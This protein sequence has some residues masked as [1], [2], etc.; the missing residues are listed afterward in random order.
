[1]NNV[2]NLLTGSLVYIACI[3]LLSLACN[4]S[5]GLPVADVIGQWLYF[6]KSALVVA[7]CLLMAGLMMEKGIF[8]YTGFVGI[9]NAGGIEAVWG[10]SQ[11]YGYAV[12][13][14]SLYV[15]TGSFFNP[16]PYSGYLAMILPVCLYQWL[17]KR[18]RFSAL[19]GMMEEDGKGDG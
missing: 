1:M 10:L 16:G 13:N 4:V 5:S 11:L 14:H 19:T 2:R 18:G 12:S 9:G 8:F 6:D 7:G 17:T 3:V 15:L